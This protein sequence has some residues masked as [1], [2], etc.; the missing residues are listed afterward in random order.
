MNKYYI[1]F[2]DYFELADIGLFSQSM[3]LAFV[4]NFKNSHNENVAIGSQQFIIEAN[5]QDYFEIPMHAFSQAGREL[6]NLVLNIASNV[7][8]D[9]YCQDFTQYIQAHGL[10]ILKNNS[11]N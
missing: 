7:H 4:L 5:M 9:N 11:E 3:R 8:T 2:S 10:N 1:E 6:R